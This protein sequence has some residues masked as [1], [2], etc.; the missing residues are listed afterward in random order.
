MTTNILE[1]QLQTQ[2]T[3]V[4]QEIEFLD[5]SIKSLLRPQTH[6]RF[7][8]SDS[9]PNINGIFIFTVGSLFKQI[10]QSKDRQD[11]L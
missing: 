9:S 10:N 2:A 7:L 4:P 5:L 6:E 11:V 3:S 8:S 1:S